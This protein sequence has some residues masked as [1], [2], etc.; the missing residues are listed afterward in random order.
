MRPRG[1]PE[2]VPDSEYQ[3]FGRP[4]LTDRLEASQKELAKKMLQDQ[5]R[6]YRERTMKEEETRQRKLQEDEEHMKR[7]RKE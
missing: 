4:D 1:L 6:L 3:Y 2:F 5:E 7:V